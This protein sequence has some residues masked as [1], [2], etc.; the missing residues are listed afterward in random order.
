MNKG[1]GATLMS[2]TSKKGLSNLFPVLHACD[3][4]NGRVEHINLRTSEEGAGTS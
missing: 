1:S 3:Y 4:R 2:R